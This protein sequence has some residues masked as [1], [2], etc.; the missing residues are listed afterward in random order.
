MRN[1]KAVGTGADHDTRRSMRTPPVPGVPI[2][3]APA[4]WV[5]GFS[6]SWEAIT[7]LSSTQRARHLGRLQPNPS[8]SCPAPM[9]GGSGS[10]V[11]MI[12]PARADRHQACH[13][14]E[15]SA[16][17]PCPRWHRA[18]GRFPGHNERNHR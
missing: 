11:A 12:S 15:S 2:A 17:G 14:P 16:A 4:T 9:R 8:Q 18:S 13:Q 5:P 1:A 6:T 7:I 10:A 3:S